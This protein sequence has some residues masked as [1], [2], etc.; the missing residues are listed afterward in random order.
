MLIRDYPKLSSK[1]MFT[2]SSVIHYKNRY[3]DVG[4]STT[5]EIQL[6]RGVRP[7]YIV[8]YPLFC[9]HVYL[10][11]SF[12]SG[13]PVHLYNIV[14]DSKLLEQASHFCLSRWWFDTWE[15]MNVAI[16]VNRFQ[17]FC[18]RISTILR[19]KICKETLIRFYMIMAVLTL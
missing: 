11:I 2:C 3:L 16:K 1:S 13:R 19:K 6:S 8:H 12:E 15:D 14:I 18:Q 4:K 9:I 10:M 17:Y 5:F 7:Q